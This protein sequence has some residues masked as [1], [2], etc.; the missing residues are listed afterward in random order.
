[1]SELPDSSKRWSSDNSFKVPCRPE[2]IKR[3]ELINCILQLKKAGWTMRQM[4]LALKLPQKQIKKI[5]FASLRRIGR[6]LAEHSEELFSLEM[7]RLEE[8]HRALYSR[9]MT[10]DVRAMDQLVRIADRRAKLLGLDAPLKIQQQTDIT[11]QALSDQELLDQARSLGLHLPTEVPKALPQYLPGESP[12]E[13]EDAQ[14]QP[15]PIPVESAPAGQETPS[16]L[17]HLPVP[18]SVPEDPFQS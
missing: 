8:M 18:K 2:K 3:S 14:Y 7:E 17:Q 10:G 12:E 4:S 5:L 9:A 1:M 6:Q 13:I 11:I 15:V 16:G